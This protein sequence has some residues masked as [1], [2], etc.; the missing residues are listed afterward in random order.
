MIILLPTFVGRSFARRT[1]VDVLCSTPM[2]LLQGSN[3]PLP[4]WT[5]GGQ[6]VGVRWE[7]SDIFDRFRMTTLRRRSVKGD[8][9]RLHHVSDIIDFIGDEQHALNVTL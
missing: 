1:P 9:Q 2:R 7:S 4:R 6:G 5:V 3:D 8:I